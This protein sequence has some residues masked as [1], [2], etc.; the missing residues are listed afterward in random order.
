VARSTFYASGRFI[1]GG[2]RLRR[3]ILDASL[4][5]GFSPRENL[6]VF[7]NVRYLGGGAVGTEED[8]PGPGDGYV[9]NWLH[10]VSV[11]LGVTVR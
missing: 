1:T 8:F 7:L 4:R 10:T 6:D 11:S 2:Q 9:R 5:G 3:S